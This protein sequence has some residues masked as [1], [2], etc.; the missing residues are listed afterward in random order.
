M[1]NEGYVIEDLDMLIRGFGPRFKA[2]ELGYFREMELK[3]GSKWLTYGQIKTFGL[4]DYLMR[5][6]DP[7]GLHYRGFYVIQYSDDDWY[8]AEFKVNRV[9]V[10]RETFDKFLLLEDI[11]VPPLDFNDEL[12]RWREQNGRRSNC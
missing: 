11:G 5:K 10:D 2:G 4:R 8:K 3:F 1:P 6:G 12:K 7:Q 9:P